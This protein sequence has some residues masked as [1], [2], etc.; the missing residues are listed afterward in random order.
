MKASVW[1]TLSVAFLIGT[2]F[3]VVIFGIIF[4]MPNQVLPA[5]LRPVQVPDKL[6]LPTA[7][8]TVFQF[9]PTWT[10]SPLP[11]TP[12]DTPIPSE[13]STVP[14]TATMEQT[15]TPGTVTPEIVGSGTYILPSTSPT[16]S[17]T[18]TR[19]ATRTSTVRIVIINGTAATYTKTKK[20]TKTQT[21]A[22]TYT[23]GGPVSFGANDDTATVGYFPASV[24]VNVLAN[25]DNRTGTPIRIVK[26]TK[27]PYHGNVD[28][29]MDNATVQYWPDEGFAGTDSF[30]YKMTNTGGLTAFAWCTI[31]VSDGSN[32]PP[33]DISIS[34]D[35]VDENLAAGLV[36]G[37][38]STT[39]AGSTFHY[40]LVSGTGS[41]GNNSFILSES[42]ELT[43][44]T[45]FN[46]EEQSVYKIRVRSVDSGGL[47]LEKVLNIYI[48]D[49]NEAP[50]IT[51]PTTATGTVYYPFVFTFRATDNDIGDL[52]NISVSPNPN[53][54]W[55]DGLEIETLTTSN[56]RIMFGY[57]TTPGT[58]VF[59]VTATDTQG[60]TDVQSFK[61]TINLPDGL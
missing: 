45:K 44:A 61:L 52:V 36:V 17:N 9:P 57:P 16:P 28:V 48:D 6:M 33:T 38:L 40:S 58:Y 24:L 46:R 54:S 59:T 47:Y 8:E 18:A 26:I 22:P 25:D 12:S 60:L 20:P 5:S 7:T 23:P 56:S 10:K 32:N 53:Y 43:T 3:L 37:Q 13:T 29:L 51:S 31:I 35:H 11:V 41:T 15:G 39:D 14:V 19:T 49:V 4:L 1:N 30:E 42:G 21:L 2:V 55:P 27:G 50:I 34:N